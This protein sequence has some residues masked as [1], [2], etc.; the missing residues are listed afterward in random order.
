[1]NLK[2]LSSGAQ[3]HLNGLS[4]INKNG[5]A[6]IKPVHFAQSQNKKSVVALLLTHKRFNQTV[7]AIAP[8]ILLMAT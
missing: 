7:G 2:S 3:Q 6:F 5:L 8:A 4:P 1:M